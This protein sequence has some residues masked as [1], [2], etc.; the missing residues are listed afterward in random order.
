MACGY[1]TTG[2]PALLISEHK[3]NA[4]VLRFSTPVS[5]QRYQGGGGYLDL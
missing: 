2:S 3:K 5:G 4:G 1:G